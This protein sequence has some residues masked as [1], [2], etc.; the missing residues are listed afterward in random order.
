METRDDETLTARGVEQNDVE[1]RSVEKRRMQR[2][3][4]LKRKA[5]E[6]GFDAVGIARLEANLHAD[7][8][9]RWLEA[10]YAGTMTYLHR[11]AARRKDP[12]LIMP[13]ARSAVVT[14]TNYFH[15]A[16][17]PETPGHGP[18]VSQPK[19]NSCLG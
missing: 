8:L 10:G 11:Q 5:L 2:E 9:D 15:S 14:L 18:G 17:T 6:L 7:A 12:R 16:G 4:E 3:A 13:E 19:R 1:K